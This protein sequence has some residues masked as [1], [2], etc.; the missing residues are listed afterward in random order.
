MKIKVKENLKTDVYKKFNGKEFDVITEMPNFYWIDTDGDKFPIPK[1]YCEVIN[2]TFTEI[3]PKMEIKVGMVDDS[4]PLPNPVKLKK[5]EI[6][7]KKNK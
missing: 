1:E 6:V 4:Y 7:P 3:E 2:L 5:S